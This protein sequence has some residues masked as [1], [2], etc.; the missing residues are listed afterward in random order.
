MKQL[1][2]TIIAVTGAFFILHLESNAQG[3]GINESSNPPHPSAGLDVDFTDRGTLIT[4]LTTLQR[5][6]IVSPAEGLQIFNLSSKCFEFFANGVWQAGICSCST[7]SAPT[8]GTHTRTG[9]DI[10]W[11]WDAVSGADGYKYNTVN[12]YASAIDN[13][14]STSYVQA[15]LDCST[16]YSL[17]VW[18]YQAECKSVAVEL[19]QTTA[20]FHASGGVV[21]M[22]GGDIVH[23]FTTS[24]TF[25]TCGST[26]AQVL[27][28]G[29]G[30]S[31]SR[32]GGGAGGYIY[33]ASFLLTEQI[34]TVA[35]GA[36]GVSN[37][38][39]EN[40]EFSTLTAIGGGHGGVAGQD[41]FPGGSG[42]GAGANNTS[43]KVGGSGTAGQGFGGG[44]S[45]NTS[46]R[47]GG[48]GGGANGA[49]GNS[50]GSPGGNGGAG[51]PSAI[52]GSTVYYAG[53]G[54]GGS[55]TC[56]ATPGSGGIGGGGNGCA[57]ES[58]TTNNA[59]NGTGGGGGGCVGG[60]NGGGGN[61]G[62]G[63]VIIRYP[64]P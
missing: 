22:V 2:T 56:C 19:T 23:T 14:T 53:G 11:S 33:E 16:A 64:A 30:G 38:D 27:V 12:E 36:G 26:N 13:G 3:V 57:T 6:A 41:G 4:R 15:G 40:S 32:G 45:T 37:T 63:I 59:V 17:F 52:S 28:V 10:T 54:G 50:N 5:D 18:A 7:P 21:S 9:V 39:G 47:G 31:G 55:F 24:G 60:C 35:V 62:S 25:S 58:C 20:S 49:G 43:S 29:G 48:G 1:F 8:E 34:Y 61:G 44:N 42:G 46:P 51:L